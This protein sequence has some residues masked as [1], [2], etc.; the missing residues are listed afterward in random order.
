MKSIIYVGMDVHKETFNLCCYSVES[1]NIFAETTVS[2]DYTNILKYLKKVEKQK[3]IECEFHLGYEAGCLGYYLCNQLFNAGVDCTILAPTTMSFSVQEKKTKN[4]RM[5]ARNIARNLAYGTYKPVYVPKQEDI[6]I[7]EYMRMRNFHKKQLKATKQAIKSLVLRQGHQYAGS[8]NWT[9]AY[10]KWLTELEMGYMARETLDEYLLNFHSLTDKI[11]RIDL[12]IEE[13]SKTEVYQT[14]TKQLEC[15]KGISTTAAM[16]INVEVSDFERFPTAKAFTSYLGLV[17]G[18]SSSG[19]KVNRTSITKQGNSVVRKTLIECSQALV[20][21]KIGIKS[22]T[23]KARQKGQDVNVIVYA[24]K[25]VERLQ[26]KFHK[27]INRG[28]K[29]NVAITA[30]ARELACF[31]W[32]MQTGNIEL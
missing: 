6:D 9:I 28:V 17:P 13:L 25:A 20:K 18:E 11:E 2:S 22:K 7:K 19:S 3:G 8:K 1:Q 5:D 31:I 21:G 4:D 12:R 32:G 29:H 23:V 14:K 26:R 27:M 16:T 24:D 15:F 10:I 30:V